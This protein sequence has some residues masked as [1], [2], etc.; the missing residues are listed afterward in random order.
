MIDKD[1]MVSQNY[2]YSKNI[3]VGLYGETYPASHDASQAMAIKAEE[4]SHA[5]EEEDLMPIM[6][7]EAKAEPEVSCMSLYVHC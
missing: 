7:Q 2:T 1:M 5:K 4:V 6:I 3:L